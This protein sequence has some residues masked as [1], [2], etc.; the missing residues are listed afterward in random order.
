MVELREMPNICSQSENYSTRNTFFFLYVWVWWHFCRERSFG[1]RSNLVSRI[2]TF[3][4]G[5]ILLPYVLSSRWISVLSVK[6]LSTPTLFFIMK[7][8]HILEWKLSHQYYEITNEVRKLW[9][10]KIKALI[11][12]TLGMFGSSKMN[13]G[14]IGLLVRFI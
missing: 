6:S 1:E 8:F 7:I 4:L 5:Q 3:N 13:P 9:I 10:I 12:L 11:Y 14:V 2:R